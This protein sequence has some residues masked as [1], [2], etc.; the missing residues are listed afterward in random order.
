LVSGWT[1]R[2]A[3]KFRIELKEFIG[4]FMTCNGIATYDGKTYSFVDH[5]ERTAAESKKER[6]MGMAR[7]KIWGG[8]MWEYLAPDP[9]SDEL[10]GKSQELRGSKE[11]GGEDCYEIQV[12]YDTPDSN[13]TTWYFSKK[14]YLPR[15]RIDHI[16]RGDQSYTLEKM[17]TNLVVDPEIT[18]DSFSMVVPD[19]YGVTEGK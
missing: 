6:V 7:R 10:S 4:T 16:N 2:G 17:V 12:V 14:D 9:F 11:I 3:E 15:G 13:Q 1:G 18:K 19:G 8:M 5:K